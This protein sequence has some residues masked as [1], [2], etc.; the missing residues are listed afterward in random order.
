MSINFTLIS[1]K[2]SS[3][4]LVSN[5]SKLRKII[6]SSQLLKWIY[7]FNLSS[8]KPSMILHLF[9]EQKLLKGKIFHIFIVFCRSWRSLVKYIRLR[10]IRKLVPEELDLIPT[11]VLGWNKR[12][13]L[14]WVLEKKERIKQFHS[15]KMNNKCQ[16]CSKAWK[17]VEERK[18]QVIALLKRKWE[19]GQRHVKI[20]IAH[21]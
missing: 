3:L 13:R 21:L 8:R 18:F 11:L 14:Q 19:Q 15:Q 2:L 4:I 16:K 6:P 20:Y 9:G 5:F 1:V 10:K 7:C 12:K 17:K